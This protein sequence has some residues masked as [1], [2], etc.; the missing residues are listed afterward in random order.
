[1]S[2]KVLKDHL[3]KNGHE[4]YSEVLA[5]KI[6]DKLEVFLTKKVSKQE[7]IKMTTEEIRSHLSKVE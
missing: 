7:L 2:M 5:V 3:K 6:V 1:M 4:Y